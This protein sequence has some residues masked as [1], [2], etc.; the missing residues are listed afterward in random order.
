MNAVALQSAPCAPAPLG[1]PLKKRSSKFDKD[2]EPITALLC[3]NGLAICKSLGIHSAHIKRSSNSP[4]VAVTVIHPETNKRVSVALWKIV[5]ARVEAGWSVEFLNGNATDLR[6]ENLVTVAPPAESNEQ[7]EDAKPQELP[8]SPEQLAKVERQRQVF[9]RLTSEEAKEFHSYL[10][11]TARNQL[12]GSFRL[13]EDV[14]SQIFAEN[15]WP[16]LM[17]GECDDEDFEGL[18]RFAAGAVAFQ[19]KF[20]ATLAKGGKWGDS[21][22]ERPRHLAKH[23]IQLLEYDCNFTDAAYA[24]INCEI[25]ARPT[26]SLGTADEQTFG[27][28]ED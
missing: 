15:V 26:R 8:L 23:K 25:P 5:T 16:R 14:A 1:L 27:Q 11:A 9:E 22:P 7:E 2:R 13:T 6:I 19:A 17:A 20:V 24:D 3:E 12:K 4:H 10:C 18:R 21:V 28:E